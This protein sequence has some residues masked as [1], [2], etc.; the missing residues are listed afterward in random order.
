MTDLAEKIGREMDRMSG[1]TGLKKKPPP[2]R[3]PSP[4]PQR[5]L[6]NSHTGRPPQIEDKPLT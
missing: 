4:F 1:L 6:D 2:Q 5:A 3:D